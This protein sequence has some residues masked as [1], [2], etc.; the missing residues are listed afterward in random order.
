MKRTPKP[1]SCS[2]CGSKRVVK[3][4]YGYPWEEDW[5]QAELGKIVLGGCVVTGDDPLWQCVDCGESFP[6]SEASRMDQGK[7]HSPEE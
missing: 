3:I 5:R 1:K 4:V 7:G 2:K 6:K